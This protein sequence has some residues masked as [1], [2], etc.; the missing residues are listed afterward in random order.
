MIIFFILSSLYLYLLNFFLIKKNILIDQNFLNKRK[1]FATSVKRIPLTGGI[2]FFSIFLIFFILTGNKIYLYSSLFSIIGIIY[3]LGFV[4]KPISRI[5]IQGATLIV[6]IYISNLYLKDLKINFINQILFFDLFSILFTSF[7][8]LVLINGSNFLD[9]L[10][11]HLSGYIILSSVFFFVAL[12]KHN[13]HTDYNVISNFILVCFVFFLFNLFNKNY[14]G[15]GGVYG[16]SFFLGYLI[17]LTYLQ[18][19]TISPFFFL[20][21]LWYPAFENLFS[22]LRRLFNKKRV[23]K[24]DNH[25]LHYKIFIFLYKNT[26]LKKIYANT[27]SSFLL[28]LF[29]FIIF[30]IASINIFKTSYQIKITILSI[31]FYLFLFFYLK[32]KNEKI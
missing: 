31:S 6:V 2:F 26:K 27:I 23:D 19:L 24:A 1:I 20:N 7:C 13:L 17:T 16:I 18:N 5:I 15:D 9:G 21:L 12:S 29:N 32:K 10:N 25:H 30:Y 11:T 28:N 8:F 14:L 22:L 4:I 3:D